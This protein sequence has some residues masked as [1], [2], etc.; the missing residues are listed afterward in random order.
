M[1]IFVAITFIFIFSFFLFNE[2]IGNCLD[3]GFSND[4]PCL[5]T[6]TITASALSREADIK[7]ESTP[8]DSVKRFK[9]RSKAPPPNEGSADDSESEH[10]YNLRIRIYDIIRV[11]TYGRV[12]E[13]GSMGEEAAASCR[14][15]QRHEWAV[16]RKVKG[17]AEEVNLTSAESTSS[18]FSQAL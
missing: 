9:K 18:L 17:A 7:P 14:D 3:G 1:C 6:Y 2:Q 15:F 12:W 16:I 4:S 5:D 13:V 11:P 10:K 8:T